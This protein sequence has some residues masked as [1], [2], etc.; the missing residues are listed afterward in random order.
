MSLRSRTILTFLLLTIT[1]LLLLSV[2]AFYQFSK[3][4]ERTAIENSEKVASLV[5]QNFDHFV[6]D[7]SRLSLYPVY[8]Q[9]VLA[10]L[11]KHDTPALQMNYSQ[12]QEKM[13]LFLSGLVFQRDELTG[14]HI[15]GNDGR[16][17][18]HLHSSEV[19]SLIQLESEGWYEDVRA[20]HGSWVLLPPHDVSYY[21]NPTIEEEE[22]ISVARLL[23]EPITNRELGV[24]KFDIAPTYFASL[25]SLLDEQGESGILLLNKEDGQLV[26]GSNW[27]LEEDIIS[28]LSP[29]NR[30]WVE[31]HGSSFLALA[32]ESMFSKTMILSF[33]PEEDIFHESNELRR[34]SIYLLLISIVMAIIL[35]F[36]SSNSVITPIRRLKESM[37]NVEKGNLEEKVTI[38]RK[39]EIGKLEEVFNDMVDEIQ[40]LIKEVYLKEINQKE[41]EYRALQSQINPHFLYNTLESVNMMALSNKQWPISEMI[42]E[43]ASFLRYSIK[44]RSTMITLREEVESVRSYVAIMKIRL[45][46]RLHVEWSV[47]E[48]ALERKVPTFII[49]PLVENAIQ[50][51]INSNDS[52][53]TVRVIVEQFEDHIGIQIQDNGIGMSRDALFDIKEKLNLRTEGI[54]VTDQNHT[55]LGLWNIHQ[56]LRLL[57][58]G[59]RGLEID[60]EWGLGT[61]VRLLIPNQHKEDKHV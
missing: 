3:T 38:G 45:A 33:I 30:G 58:H 28:D 13:S 18:S 23:R 2:F 19:Y 40:Y 60:S 21:R 50:H 46:D 7:L 4:L 9:S 39:D 25:I 20:Q 61:T 5:S 57:F 55:R 32:N 6:K 59:N 48:Q 54:Q 43:L 34:V 51:G 24:I 56:R 22:V 31:L 1:P 44:Q 10:I 42:T 53:G 47:D 26:Y 15:F 11:K 27:Y 35:A 16:V 49:Q 17:Y 29:A 36:I 8:D 52:G 41:A 37:E 14:A 12:Q